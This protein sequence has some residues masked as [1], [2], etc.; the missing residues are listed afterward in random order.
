MSSSNTGDSFQ[1]ESPE[2]RGVRVLIVEDSWDVST[3]LKILL[4]AQGIEVVGPAATVNEARRLSSESIP[5]VAL[6]DINLR[7]GELSYG[8]IDEIGAQGIP[9][10]VITGYANASTAIDKAVAI[11][12]KPFSEEELLAALR[13]AKRGGV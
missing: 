1:F 4:E 3:E 6:L 13:A 10:V 12:Q 8:L 9:V 5:D 11:L 2:F 7:S